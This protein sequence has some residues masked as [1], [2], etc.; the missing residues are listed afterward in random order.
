MKKREQDITDTS[1]EIRNSKQERANAKRKFTRKTIGLQEMMMNNSPV[2]ALKEK[3]DEVKE[4]YRHLEN[5]N[6]LV[7]FAIN[8]NAPHHLID[9]LLEECDEYM[10]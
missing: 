3:F 2:M 4:A 1:K 10:I 9:G 6:E 7:N 5:C 8:E